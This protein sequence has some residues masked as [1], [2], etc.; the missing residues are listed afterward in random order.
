[1]DCDPKSI[2]AAASC[3]LCLTEKQM[4]AIKAYLL[5]QFSNIPALIFIS[6]LWLGLPALAVDVSASFTPNYRDELQGQ[7]K[8]YSLW[9]QPVNDPDPNDHKW[10]AQ[11]QI[12]QSNIVVNATNLPPKCWLFVNANGLSVAG[13]YSDPY[14]YDYTNLLAHMPLSKVGGLNVMLK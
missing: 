1:M 12:G 5:C 13:P 3:F 4:Q 7:V 6:L 10:L 14:F 2:L 8:T 9:Y 11:C